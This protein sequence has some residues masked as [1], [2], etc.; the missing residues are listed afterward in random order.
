M[1]EYNDDDLFADSTMSFGEHLEVLRGHLIKALFGVLIGTILGLVLGGRIIG[2][3]K[4]PLEATLRKYAYLEEAKA[5]GELEDEGIWG[6]VRNQLGLTIFDDTP[7]VDDTNDETRGA[8]AATLSE[9]NDAIR[10]DV[11]L[12]QLMDALHEASPEKFDEPPASM[13][14]KSVPITIA[15]R[16]FARFRG[17]ALKGSEPI[18]LTVQEGFF[19][20]LKVSFIAGFV[21]ASPWVFYQAWQF[22]AAGLYPHE[23]KYVYRFGPMSF[24]LFS[25]GV[26]F[27]FFVVLPFALEFFIGFSSR[28]GLTPQIRIGEW[29]SFAVFLP[30]L[31][32]IAFQMPIVMLFLERIGV[33]EVT[34]YRSKRNIATFVIAIVSM[35]LTPQDPITMILMMI[36][37]MLL[38]ELGIWL[39]KLSGPVNPFDGD[40]PAAA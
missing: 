23:R 19:T 16:E 31:F 11:S 21:F 33:F 1:P 8:S 7:G 14:D 32:G 28:L 18:T 29:I 30:V 13:L 4:R 17:A 10:V 38:Y 5:V 39:C 36:P 12:Y 20:Y 34:D 2:E 25:A 24:V 26:A 6:W 9:R 37:L 27:A 22:V 40:V 3:I 35:I 15:A